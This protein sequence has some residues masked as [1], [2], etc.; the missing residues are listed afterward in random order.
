P[1]SPTDR[2]GSKRPVGAKRRPLDW[3]RDVHSGD[4]TAHITIVPS[5]RPAPAETPRP[6]ISTE[7]SSG[8]TERS[9]PTSAGP[10]P[11]SSATPTADGTKLPCSSPD[12]L[13]PRQDDAVVATTPAAAMVGGADTF[14]A[15]EVRA[16]GAD[17]ILS[18]CRRGDYLGA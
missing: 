6:A 3:E 2:P 7:Q 14:V 13:V 15:S 9:A 1:S 17:E 8:A 12:V 10:I 11:G 18:F 16:D 4:P 5:S